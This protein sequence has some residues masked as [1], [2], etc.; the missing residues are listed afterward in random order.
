MEKQTILYVIPA[1]YLY[2]LKTSH[3]ARTHF[4]RIELVRWHAEEDHFQVHS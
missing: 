1:A 4:R 3:L 2:E